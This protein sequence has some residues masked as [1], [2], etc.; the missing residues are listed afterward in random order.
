MDDDGYETEHC[1]LPIVERCTQ[2]GKKRDVGFI[3]CRDHW[4]VGLDDPMAH[5]RDPVINAFEDIRAARQ[6]WALW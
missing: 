3:T 6:R 2:C 5:R 4:G 1:S